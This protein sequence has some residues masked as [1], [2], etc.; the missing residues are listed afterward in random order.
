MSA[1]LISVSNVEA[2]PE[3]PAAPRLISEGL[4]RG[5][6]DHAGIVTGRAPARA[7]LETVIGD[8]D[9]QEVP[10]AGADPWRRICQL[11]LKGP[12]GDF[13]GT[14]WFAGPA[15]VITAG[16]CVHYK[17][18]F[19]GWAEEIIVSPGRHGDTRPIST[20]TSHRF[21]VPQIWRDTKDKDFDIGCIHLDTALGDQAGIFAFA[22]LPDTEL[23]NQRIN[24]AGYPFDLGDGHVQFHHASSI[25]A[26]TPR[27]IFY[28]ADTVRGQS[29]APVFMVDAPG[30]EP[31]VVAV[32]AYGTPGTPAE[33]NLVA[34]SAP[35][36][37]PE[38]FDLISRWVAEDNARLGLAEVSGG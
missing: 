37:R 22:S 23:R 12:R 34:N 9:R 5:A 36:L 13:I 18:L 8:D 31:V 16:H 6:P 7:M 27:R 17:A 35:R 1:G 2:A 14:G 25:G 26:M 21:S 28:E 15:T 32:H 4:R 20:A 30:A 3:A 10:D 11:D 24:V 33:L 38:M 19:R 29:G